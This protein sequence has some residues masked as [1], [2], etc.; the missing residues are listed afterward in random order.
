MKVPNIN[1]KGSA[2]V[3]FCALTGCGAAS[4]TVGVV[5]GA[6]GG[7]ATTVGGA[8]GTAVKTTTKTAAKTAAKVATTATSSATN[9]AAGLATSTATGASAAVTPL[10][11]GVAASSAASSLDPS[12]T[13]DTNLDIAGERIGQEI[14]AGLLFC[15]NLKQDEYR[16]DCYADQLDQV[17]KTVPDDPDLG[18]ARSI[19]SNTAAELSEITQRRASKT[20][21]PVTISSATGSGRS[22]ARAVQA[23]ATGELS[24]ALAEAE[25]VLEEAE[26]LLLRASETSERRK[27]AYTRISQSV[28]STKI[29]LRSA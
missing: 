12:Q 18:A 21:R 2:F 19:L 6:V 15:V 13:T 3:L 24:Q 4:T 11:T 26:T 7:V 10:A 1:R 29:L 17:A 27:L 25:Q 28:G 14:V 22:S 20:L 8:V 9:A 16:I 5:G 23:V